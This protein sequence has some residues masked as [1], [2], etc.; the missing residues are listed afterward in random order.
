MASKI[1]S[2]LMDKIFRTDYDVKEVPEV[3]GGYAETKTL[4]FMKSTISVTKGAPPSTLGHEVYHVLQRR[5]NPL[6]YN[7]NRRLAPGSLVDPVE[8]EAEA[9]GRY[10][11]RMLEGTKKAGMSAPSMDA[12]LKALMAIQSYQKK[13]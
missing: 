9:A 5:Q 3:K 13:R 10:F 7:L 11:E 4:P 2:R 12:V 8:R 6:R 1:I